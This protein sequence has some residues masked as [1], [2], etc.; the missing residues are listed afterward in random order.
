MRQFVLLAG[1]HARSLR[2]SY[3]TSPGDRRR[4]LVLALLAVF[5]SIGVYGGAHWFFSRCLEIEPIG[6]IVVR[7]A[8]AMVLLAIFSL[9]A[10][11]S[12][13]GA[14]S[15]LYLAEDLQLLISRPVGAYS[16]YAA[17]FFQT[18]VLASWMVIPFSTPIFVAIGRL[19]GAGP[20]FYASLAAVYVAMAAIP[21]AIGVIVSL[22]LTSVLSARRARHVL[23]T[24]GALALGVLVFLLRRLEP[25]KL[26]NPD[27]GAPL[28]DALRTM[29]G[30]DPA[31]LPSSWAL[32]ALWPHLAWS[33]KTGGHPVALLLSTSVMMFFLGGWFFRALH[34]GAFSRAQEGLHR[35]A[36]RRRLGKRTT[37]GRP[38]SEIL[39]Y[40]AGLRKKDR[41]IFVRDPAQ[42]SQMLTLAAIVAIYVLNFKYIRVIA[43]TGMISDLGLHFLNL[44]LCGF[45]VVALAVRFVYPAVSLEGPAF[46]L[47]LSA[48][49]SMRSFLRAK[50]AAWFLP[51]AF[52]AALLMVTTHVFLGTDPW[53]SVLSI[54]T[55][56]PIAFGV[57]GLAIGLGARYPRFDADNPVEVA[58]G[59][60][61]LFFM[62]TGGALL[63]A[64]TLLSIWPTIV[65]LRGVHRPD[66]LQA[67]H[68]LTAGIC[69]A[70]ILG[71]PMF[72]RSRA[73][74]VGARHLDVIPDREA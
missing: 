37:F 27:L 26:M 56:T 19:L 54:L 41:L 69:A 16:L 21:T 74:R 3:R 30:L 31:W 22:L 29:Q 50:A 71:L 70:L 38:S 58:T 67:L 13:V 7:R 47:I 18:S 61:G 68:G 33:G 12:L 1:V 11:S 73:L 15:N 63:L 44:G 35:P 36:G 24:V 65:V 59:F 48:P 60:G 43:G 25:E 5:F 51:L 64:V 49:Q 39:E 10:F 20:V 62:L 53:L 28:I 9:L 8:L 57:V 34:P 52:F 46:W 32:D 2:N 40:G 6:E 55:I 42:W 45:I 66:S 72:I 23:V 17:R 4:L 14:F